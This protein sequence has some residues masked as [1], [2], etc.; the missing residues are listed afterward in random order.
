MTRKRSFQT[1]AESFLNPNLESDLSAATRD[2]FSH[3]RIY[4]P[5]AH[6][7]YLDIM[8]FHLNRTI[9]IQENGLVL[10]RK[11]FWLT[12]TPDGLFSDKSNEDFRQIGLIGIKYKSK[13][14]CKITD[15]VHDQP[16]FVKYEN[17]VPVLKK[18]SQTAV[19]HKY[20][21]QWGFLK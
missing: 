3:D 10:Q 5:V 9:D 15:L 18:I 19:I 4:Q 12:A 17:G 8:N 6:E 2:A 20:K 11:L 14:N 1:L 7:K 16:F 21:W 13:K